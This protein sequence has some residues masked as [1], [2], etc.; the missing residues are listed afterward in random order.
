VIA[1]RLIKVSS[2]NFEATV[3]VIHDLDPWA[4]TAIINQP[5]TRVA[6]TN[7]VEQFS[8]A[9]AQEKRPEL[10]TLTVDELVELMSTW[11]KESRQLVEAVPND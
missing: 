2:P 7:T 1:P 5:D 6:F 3:P 4:L 8:L 10:M 9:L 11:I